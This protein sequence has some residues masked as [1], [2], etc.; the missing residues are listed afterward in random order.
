MHWKIFI[1]DYIIK[2]SYFMKD[3]NACSMGSFH[4]TFIHDKNIANGNH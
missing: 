4:V 2:E 1:F 3:S